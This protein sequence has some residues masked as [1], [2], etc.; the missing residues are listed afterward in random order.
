[1]SSDWENI[2]KLIEHPGS[3]ETSQKTIEEW[4]FVQ[5]LVLIQLFK[6]HQLCICNV[7]HQFKDYINPD[8][9]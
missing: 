1:M 9:T 3:V 6:R 7:L 5:I 2:Y 8:G 4:V